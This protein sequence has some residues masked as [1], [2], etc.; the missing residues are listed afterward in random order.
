MSVAPG[1]QFSFN[2]P[3]NIMSIAKYSKLSFL[4]GIVPAWDVP[5]SFMESKAKYF[6]LPVNANKIVYANMMTTFRGLCVCL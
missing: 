3:M 4:K 6:Y 1:K 5:W 2:I